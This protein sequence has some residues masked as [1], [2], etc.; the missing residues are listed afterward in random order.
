MALNFT[1]EY[2]EVFLL[3]L[4]RVSAFLVSAPFFSLSRIP[5]QVKA[6]LAF[7][8]SLLLFSSLGVRTVEYN[9]MIELAFLII[10]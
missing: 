4:V 6:S 3:I 2:L 9:G 8:I 10:K 1:V 5:R 7:Y